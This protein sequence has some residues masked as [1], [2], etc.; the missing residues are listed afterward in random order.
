MPR[1]SVVRARVVGVLKL[2]DG[3]E[4]DDKILAVMDGN[5]LAAAGSIQDLNDKFPGVTTIVET[6]FVSYKGP[7]QLESK[8]FAGPE[9]GMNIIESAAAA[10]AD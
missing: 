8:G 4:Q 3:G 6:W 9:E 1:G 2:L 10:F 7:G 5:P